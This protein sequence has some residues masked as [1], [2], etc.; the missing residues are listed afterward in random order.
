MDA[1]VEELSGTE[2][3]Q[4]TFSGL[5][6]NVKSSLA[7]KIGPGPNYLDP[8]NVS[9]DSKGRLRMRINHATNGHWTCAEISTEGIFDVGTYEFHTCAPI[10]A[11]MDRFMVLG[12]FCYD[13]SG[14]SVDGTNEIDIELARWGNP[15]WPNGN[16]T[17]WGAEVLQNKG[18]VASF[19]FQSALSSASGITRWRFVRIAATPSS[20]A[21]IVWQVFNL[22]NNLIKTW[23]VADNNKVPTKPLNVH[24]NFWLY[25]GIPP[26]DPVAPGK[27]QLEIALTKFTYKPA[28]DLS[29]PVDELGP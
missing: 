29:D 20:P 26:E 3:T 12:M 24:I 8:A 9:V 22:D 19:T 1:I 14:E 28:V 21:K 10:T 11:M 27:T 2:A 4:V 15:D 5:T 16:F 17:A 7:G 23:E 25:Q 6:W 18:Q 13:G